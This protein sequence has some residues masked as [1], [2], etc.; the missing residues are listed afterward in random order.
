MIHFVQMK[1]EESIYSYFKLPLKL[2][3]VC[4]FLILL[5]S[6]RNTDDDV[7]KPSCETLQL[8]RQ[9][10]TFKNSV[11]VNEYNAVKKNKLLK[12]NGRDSR[13]Q[14]IDG[15]G[16]DWFE[17]VVVGDGIAG[18]TIDMR[19]WRIIVSECDGGRK[20]KTI[21]L[22]NDDYWS[23]VLAGTILTFIEDNNNNLET[24]IDI[25]DNLSTL[26]W[27][28]TNIWTGNRQYSIGDDTFPTSNEDTQIGILDSDGNL[29]FG[30]VG[31]GINP[32]SGIGSDEIFILEDDPLPKSKDNMNYNEG[33]NS[34]FGKPNPGQNFDRYRI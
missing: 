6:C 3:F 21:I 16:G 1:K 30:P 5:N 34:T 15:N 7:I 25:E 8:D 4:F 19:G 28:W 9:I 33:H 2:V 14:R 32:E 20:I 22:S 18:T 29:V 11:I 26:G 27:V 24:G 31:E 23:N 10:S 13:F 12:S 17:L